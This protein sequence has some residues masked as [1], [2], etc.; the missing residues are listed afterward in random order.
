MFKINSIL[1]MMFITMSY[2]NAEVV[3]II[4]ADKVTSG[5]NLRSS[6]TRDVWFSKWGYTTDA[7]TAQGLSQAVIGTIA[8]NSRTAL[9]LRCTPIIK[10]GAAHLDVRVYYRN[11]IGYNDGGTFLLTRFDSE[12]APRK[13][14]TK[15]ID[16]VSMINGK[17]I[18]LKDWVSKA[19]AG[20]T[21]HV[22]HRGDMSYGE[23]GSFS[24]SG[25]TKA[26]NHMIKNCK[27]IAMA[28]LSAQK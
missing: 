16:S 20:R 7:N 17:A 5:Y 15:N 24:L 25:F 8:G 18:S 26:Y 2:A 19:K 22:S 4:P 12:S 21:Y 14:W 6:V 11:G 13:I 1:A 23:F 9:G 3:E 27:A 28:K 10:A